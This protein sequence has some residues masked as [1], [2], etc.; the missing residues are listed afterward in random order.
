MKR[1]IQAYIRALRESDMFT[2]VYLT[3]C[4]LGVLACVCAS[5]WAA[6]FC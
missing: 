1:F 6:W 2:I 4:G 5:A 3:L